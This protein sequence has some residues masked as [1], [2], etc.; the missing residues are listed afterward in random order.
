[1]ANFLSKIYS[2]GASNLVEAVGKAADN[3]FTSDEER[4]ELETGLAKAEMQHK[5]ES[6]GQIL[7][8]IDSARVNNS[9]V[10]ES[11]H[12]SWLAKNI[13]PMLA[14]LI[15]GM[16]FV[17]YFWVIGRGPQDLESSGMKEIII[18]ILGALTTVS[19]QVAAFYF[20][21]SAGSK[22]KQHELSGIIAKNNKHKN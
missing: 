22:D 11:A 1:M 19:T 10:Q 17:M 14:V 12:S 13:G 9:R 5:R 6:A 21:S 2:A 4:L 7:D 18:Y 16:T 8:D 3:M 15:I 20:G